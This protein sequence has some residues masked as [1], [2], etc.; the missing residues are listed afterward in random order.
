MYPQALRSGTGVGPLSLQWMHDGEPVTD[1]QT[2]HGS[3]I[4]GADT[5]TLS[6]SNVQPE[7]AGS[8]R[9]LASNDCG[10]TL[11]EPGILTV[12]VPPDLPTSWTVTNLHPAFADSSRAL[13]V[14]GDVQAGVTVFDT[15]E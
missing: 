6:I 13:D 9:L 12:R 1:G 3:T 11:S 5:Q 15:P 10:T 7:D 4:A 2:P 14:D 8:Y